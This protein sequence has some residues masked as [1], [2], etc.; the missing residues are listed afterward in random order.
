MLLAVLGRHATTADERGR[1]LRRHRRRHRCANEPACDLGIALALASA[2][3]ELPIPPTV[4]AIGEVSLSG[5]VRRVPNL[6]RRLAEA[7]RLGFT[8]VLVPARARRRGAAARA[9]RGRPHR[10]GRD[11]Q[12]RDG[13]DRSAVA[14]RRRPAPR[15]AASDRGRKSRHTRNTNPIDCSHHGHDRTRRGTARRPRPGRARHRAARRSRAHPARQHRRADRDRLGP[16]RRGA[17]HRR[18]PA[19]RRRVLGHAAARAV[20]DGRRGRAEHRRHPDVPRRHAPDARPGDPDRGVRHPAPHRAA[21]RPADRLPGHLGVAVDEDHQPVH[22]R[23][24]LRAREHRRA[25]HPRQPGDQHPRALQGPPR[26]GVE[27]AVGAR[28]RGPRHRARRRRRRPT[29][30]DGAPHRRRGHRPGRR[31]RHRRAP[32]RPAARRADGRRRPR[33]R[34]DRARLHAQPDG[35]RAPRSRSP[36]NSPSCRRSTC[37]TRAR[38]PGRWACPA[39]RRVST[40]RPARAGTGC[41]RACPRLPGAILDR[42]VEHFG[43]LQ[44]LLAASA[45]DLQVVDGVGET[46]ARAVR[47]AISRLAEVSIIDRYS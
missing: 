47:E 35:A 20:Q 24:P 36:P 21:G 44:K 3:R 26:R 34:P 32:A 23:A 1:G 27:L 16:D 11:D 14:P 40:R 28:D 4:C 22:R 45:E 9:G 30:R 10:P 19:R 13:V 33:P 31:A 38:S 15:R 42:V 43:G 18:L 41:S 7:G 2:V 8:T 12:R 25:A 17:V 6:A 39:R 37:S 46:R 29:A 5:D